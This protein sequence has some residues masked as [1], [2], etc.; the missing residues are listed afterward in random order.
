LSL[1]LE[2]HSKEFLFYPIL[3]NIDEGILI[4]DTSLQVIFFNEHAE[5]I[6]HIDAEDIIGQHADNLKP[7]LNFEAM[8]SNQQQLVKD[9]EIINGDEVVV[10]KGLL[11]LAPG[12]FAAYAILRNT[13]SIEES[14]LNSLLQ[15]PYEGIVVFN[16]NLHLI[17]ANDVCFRF[18][19]CNSKNELYDELISL[20]PRTSLQD[21]MKKAKPVAGKIINLRGKLFELV[22]LPV[23]R[24]NRPIGIIV[25]GIP[26]YRQERTWGQMVEQYKH[27]TAQYYLDNIIGSNQ[28]LEI[29][30]ELAA[31]AARTISTVLITG[32]SGTGKE[33]FAHA[34]HNISPRRKGPFIK[35]NCAA[36]PETLLESELFGYSEGA[37]TG[38][39][40]EGKP[41]KFELANHGT[42]F[43]DEIGDMSLSMQAKL[44][45][46]LQE[47]EVERVGSIRPTRVNI[48]V[49]AATNQDLHK[50]VAENKFREDLFYRLNVIV[51]NLPPLRVRIDD[52]PV[53]STALLQ[54]LNQE[55]G[56]R[57]SQINNEVIDCFCHYDW[58]GNVRELENTLER[59]INFCEGNTIT[60]EHIP[61]HI[62]TGR[63]SASPISN[64]HGTLE[65]LLEQRE[66]ELIIAT[67]ENY[68]GNKTR[69]AQALDIH[70][71]VL[72]RKINKYNIHTL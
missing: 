49:I 10:V 11:E 15:T 69:A 65:N 71:S 26:A 14:Q 62:K 50:L 32:E 17:Y 23:I 55:L 19:K 38:A 41:G 22:F 51:L 54:R 58:P 37:F 67:L 4:T 47:K 9:K 63:V 27:G 13:Y 7:D 53:I 35:V 39:R 43:L 20:V 56:T 59:A 45:R 42:I 46:V 70:R 1:N 34:I 31:K 66:K 40:K 61:Q 33:I 28:Q 5:K 3:Q 57:V 30:K 72:Y 6:Y 44:L 2:L 52:I 21:S 36:V 60:L 24:Y 48:R 64:S 25:K 8:I 12:N 16:D 18:F 29:Q 68:G